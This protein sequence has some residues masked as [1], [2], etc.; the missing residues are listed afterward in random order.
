M[1]NTVYAHL[2]TKVKTPIKAAALAYA[3]SAFNCWNINPGDWLGDAR[4]TCV[5][6][7]LAFWFILGMV[8]EA[9]K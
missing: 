6:M 3:L 7:F 4:G 2:G 1:S 9:T 8:R 5:F